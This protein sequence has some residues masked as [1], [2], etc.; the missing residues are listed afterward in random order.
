MTWKS[1]YFTFEEMTASA[2]AKRM[3][4][5]NQPSEK[6]VENLQQLVAHVLDPLREVWQQPIIVTSGYRCSRLNAAVGGAVKSQHCLGQAADIRTVSDRR[7]D[8]MAL[9]RCL[10]QAK[11]PFDQ[12]IA[13]HVDSRGR[14]DWI[15]VS[16]S[17]RHRGVFLE[18]KG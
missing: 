7:E 17:P 11:L 18:V 4:I 9:L 10:L 12:L 3:R 13:E 1:K 8:N 2:T 6:I 14:P 5:D 16:Y 15:H